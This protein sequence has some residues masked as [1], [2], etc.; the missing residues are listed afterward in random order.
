MFLV[1]VINL[2]KRRKLKERSK[3]K[4]NLGKNKKNKT[5]IKH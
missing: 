1:R 4:D 3:T 5:I 2:R